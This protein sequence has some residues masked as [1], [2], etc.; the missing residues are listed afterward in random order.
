MDKIKILNALQKEGFK[1]ID[2]IEYKK[3]I[4]VFNFL[5]VFDETELDTA[6]GYANE[7]HDDKSGEDEWYNEFFLPYLVDMATDNVRDTLNDL[8]DDMDL[9]GEFVIYEP[10]KDNYEGME[11][12]L[13]LAKQDVEFDVDNVIEELEL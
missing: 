6:K 12:I 1:E 5:Y 4:L 2:E 13:V 10:D 7:N 3:D 8:C 11:F 9:S